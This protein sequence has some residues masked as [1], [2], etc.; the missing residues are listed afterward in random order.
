MKR[1]S[2]SDDDTEHD[3]KSSKSMDTKYNSGSDSDDGRATK[4]KLVCMPLLCVVTLRIFVVGT[5]EQRTGGKE[6]QQRREQQL[7]RLAV[8]HPTASATSGA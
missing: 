5:G 2:P 8:K 1:A 3:G 6:R 4:P 7:Q